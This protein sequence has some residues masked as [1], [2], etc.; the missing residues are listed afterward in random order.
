MFI[1]RKPKVFNSGFST[2][3]KPFKLEKTTISSTL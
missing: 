1:F 3:V 2:K